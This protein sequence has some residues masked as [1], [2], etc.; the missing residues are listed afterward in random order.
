[1]DTP[2]AIAQRIFKCTDRDLILGMF[3]ESTLARISQLKGADEAAEL[4]K[5]LGTRGS[6]TSFFRYPAKDILRLLE[7]GGQKVGME[8]SAAIEDFGRQAV[9]NFFES[10]IGK[11]MLLIGGDSPAR[12]ISSSPAGYRACTSYGERT[13]QKTGER[14]ASLRFTGEFLGP[15]WPSGNIKQAIETAYK[16]SPKIEIAPRDQALMDFDILVS[17]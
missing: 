7:V 2:K 16:I 14:S 5:Q 9:K 6:Y 15:A 4:R 8:F 11:T 10:P 13:Y 17:W 3:F 1:M 12:L